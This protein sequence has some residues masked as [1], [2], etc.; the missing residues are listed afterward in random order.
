M[1]KILMPLLL[2]P[3]IILTSCSTFFDFSEA[4]DAYY[5]GDY[6]K[7]YSFLLFNS[8]QI[9]KKQGSIVYNLDEGIVTHASK[10]YKLSNISLAKAEKA[11]EENFT[12]S[13]SAS[14]GSYLI[15]ESIRDYESSFYEDIYSNIFLSLNYY[16]LDKIEDAM[17]EVRR[18]LEKLQLREQTL[19]QL[20][21]ALENQL[22]DNNARDVD[23]QLKS[24]DSSFYSSALSY[25]LSSLFAFEYGD[26]DTFRISREKG[27][28]TFKI[29][30][31]YY[32][33]NEYSSFSNLA[34]MD[35]DNSM[36]NFIAFS[37]LSPIKKTQVDRNVLV[38]DSYVDDNGVYHKPYYTNVVYSIPQERGSIVK[39]IEVLIDGNKYTLEPFE[40]LGL[41]A[42]ETMAQTCSGE[43][44]RAYIRAVSREI[45]K[46][47][48]DA[49]TLEEGDT[50]VESSLFSDL[51]T[52]FS[53]VAEG[54]GDLRSSHFFP[55]MS[56]IGT[57]EL[58][59]GKYD[60]V[61]NYL[62]SRNDIVYQEK[63]NNFKV[64]QGKANLVEVLSAK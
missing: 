57:F 34:N 31:D 23:N 28:A 41:I 11:I 26:L 44:V 8:P 21:S 6:E 56:W 7:A 37:G 39:S 64:T 2:V 59:P 3:F 58:D 18:S 13:I 55:S 29:L 47:S 33:K 17:V 27:E 4:Q 25:Y 43:Y 35:K 12:K 61:V 52:M 53:Y 62:N 32:E 50:E 51:F 48:A 40:N 15:N 14:V 54:S 42:Y 1:K 22:V 9:L 20:K 36:I 46:A 30:S 38:L 16:H 19:P 24:F 49:S 63:I 45:A 60:I 5:Q 10:D